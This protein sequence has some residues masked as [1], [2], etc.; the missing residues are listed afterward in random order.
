VEIATATATGA[1]AVLAIATDRPRSSFAMRRY[2]RNGAQYGSAASRTEVAEH[3][4]VTEAPRQSGSRGHVRVLVDRAHAEGIA[5]MAETSTSTPESPRA[6]PWPPDI[7]PEG[8]FQ[9][10]FAEIAELAG[11]L[12][13]EIRNPLSTMRLTLDLLAEEFRAPQDQRERRVLHKVERLQSESQRLQ[14]ILEDFLR[15]VRIQELK[16][17]PADL[18]AVV[19]DLRDFCEPKASSQGVIVRA[20]LAENL[21]LAPLDVELFKQ[22]LLNLILNA[23]LA[24]PEGGELILT[25]RPD[26]DSVVLEV[27]DTGC[28]IAS[29]VQPK[30]FDAFFS[31]RPGGSGLGLPTTR[32]IVV[33]HGGTICLQSE[34]GKGSKFIVRLPRAPQPAPNPELAQER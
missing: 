21:P 7:D 24:M 27:T 29:E 6:A 12:A 26:G 20:H 19:D 28:G 10:Q 16:R 1:P 30:V 8:R 31:T 32:K 9:A 4:S 11:G 17:A 18:N 3:G 13:H 22:A 15:F 25:T 5:Q 34:P 14:D 33:A 23:L 2:L